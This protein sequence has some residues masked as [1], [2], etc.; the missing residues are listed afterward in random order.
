VTC[1]R[2]KDLP[3]R[4]AFLAFL[5]TKPRHHKQGHP[6]LS[7]KRNLKTRRRKMDWVTSPLYESQDLGRCS[8]SGLCYIK[9]GKP[10]RSIKS[11]LT[12]GAA[13]RTSR[14]QDFTPISASTFLTQAARVTVPESGLNFRVYYTPPIVKGPEGKTTRRHTMQH[15]FLTPIRNCTGVP[16]RCWV[17]WS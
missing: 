3:C 5:D 11:H 14:T 1:R 7:L 12:Q 2:C 6:G 4:L 13:P 8:Q 17:F 10:L 9:S 15:T 16:S